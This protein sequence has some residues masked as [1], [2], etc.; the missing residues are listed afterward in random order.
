[1]DQLSPRTEELLR[2]AG[3]YPGRSVDIE[4]IT[5][6]LQAGGYPVT[7]TVK[8]FLTEF[9]DLSIPSGWGGE[10]ISTI[11]RHLDTGEREIAPIRRHLN[12]DMCTVANLA[13]AGWLL[14]GVDDNIY[15]TDANSTFNLVGRTIYEAIDN[16]LNLKKIRVVLTGEVLREIVPPYD[17]LP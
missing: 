12:L 1:M 15:F 16:L 8:E 7:E 3:W 9:G 2:R 10:H 5:A 13:S 17:G 11:F 14:I 4:Q 6:R